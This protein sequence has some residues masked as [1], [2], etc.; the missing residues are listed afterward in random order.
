VAPGSEL[1]HSLRPQLEQL[2]SGDNVQWQEAPAGR[3][4]ADALGRLR[5][6][7]QRLAELADALGVLDPQAGPADHPG[8]RALLNELERLIL[9]SPIRQGPWGVE[10]VQRA[11]L[12]EALA[13]PVQAWP[14]GT[15]VLNRRNLSEQELANGDIGVLVAGEGGQRLVLFPG[16]RLLHPAQLAGAE[17]A[18]ALTVHKA[19]GSQYG[20]VLLLLPAGRQLDARLLYTGLTRAR[21]SARLYTDL[22]SA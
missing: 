16:G 21:S 4:P 5:E 6:H 8:A 19:Q 11:L 2:R 9:L 17:P 22:R 14:L 13:R 3:P 15:P 10:G 1:L 18:L 20:E 7:Q 12:G